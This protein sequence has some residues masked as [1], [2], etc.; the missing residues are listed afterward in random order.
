MGACVNSGRVSILSDG[1]RDMAG[2]F[3]VSAD[4]S[5]EE[6]LSKAQED[7]EEEEEEEEEE[8]EKEGRGGGGGEGGGGEEVEEK[9]KEEGGFI[10][11]IIP[12][13][14]VDRCSWHVASSLLVRCVSRSLVALRTGSWFG[15]V[16]TE[17]DKRLLI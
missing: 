10:E 14:R 2:G 7:N 13:G 8:Q 15:L 9:D 3:G 6:D 4:L 12:A 5:V 11:D 17:S 16:L 1:T